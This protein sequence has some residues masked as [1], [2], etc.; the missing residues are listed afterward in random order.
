LHLFRDQCFTHIKERLRTAI[1]NQI[2][3]DRNNEMVDLNVL[4]T[5]IYTFV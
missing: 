3:K 4:K 2:S 1:L 5:A